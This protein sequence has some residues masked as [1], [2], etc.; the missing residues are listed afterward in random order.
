MAINLKNL[1]KIALVA[2][3]L[4]I[5][6]G[7]AVQAKFLTDHL[8]SNGY[9]VEFIP[10]DPPFPKGIRWLKRLPVVRT[11]ANQGL[12]LPSLGRLRD[13]DV[14]QILSASYWSFLLAPA[15]AILAAR[16]LKKP[17]ILNYHSGEAADHLAHWGSLVHPWLKMVDQ[18]IVP[19]S[20]LRDVFA[21]HGY[22]AQV[23]Q[24]MVDTGRFRYRRRNPLAPAF[25]SVRN[26]EPHYGVEYTLL[27]FALLRT[28]FPGATLTI[29]G[30]GPQEAELKHLGEA[31][32]LR[33]VRFI[34]PVTP[35]SM[36]SLYDAHSIFLNS[37]FVDN[38]PL[39][40]L[41][42]MASGMPVVTT[43][44]GD[45]PNMITDGITGTLVPVGD[46]AA[47]AKAVTQL[48]RWPER[49]LLTAQRAK[50][51]LGRYNWASVGPAW[52][53][54]YRRLSYS[55]RMLKAA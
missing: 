54:L 39:S 34:G 24:N 32:A 41:E 49:A 16:R 42:A 8:R 40:V 14:V 29:A 22:Q 15:P 1:P 10:I 47:M 55:C 13:A 25:L 23:I 18:I 4:R 3:S 21:R 11:L 26:F 50:E 53:E 44:V 38:Q 36:P 52:A 7:Q 31:L 9:Q 33:N 51:S 30:M 35:E 6:G 17:I 5:L 19:S 48:L 43:G 12:Y 46:P 27:A 2:P 28:T 45:I 37:S 20:F